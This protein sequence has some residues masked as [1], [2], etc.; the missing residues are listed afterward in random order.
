MKQMKMNQRSR[1]LRFAPA[2]IA[3]WAAATSAG[4]AQGVSGVTATLS[5]APG[6]GNTYDYTLT[7]FNGGA[8]PVEG[9]W[10]AWI[11]G[12]FYLPSQPSSA[13]GG[14]SGWTGSIV[15]NSIQF[16]GGAGTALDQGSSD[17]FAF[18]TTDSPTALAGDTGG[19]V[20]IGTSYAFPGAVGGNV[21]GA[22]E[23]VVQSVPE[24]SALGLLAAGS[25]FFWAI[26]RKMTE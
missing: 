3:G 10:Y 8:T 7:L 16:K 12:A 18:V 17:A 11:P 26:G 5:G 22:E 4:E 2:I 21:T 24:P 20:P 15:N 14:S 23:F 9:L 25:L 13:A 19:G 1:F 6:A